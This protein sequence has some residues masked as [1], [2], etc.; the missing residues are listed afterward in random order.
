MCVLAHGLNET[1]RDWRKIRMAQG[2]GPV[3][4]GRGEDWVTWMLGFREWVIK[5]IKQQ[6][7]IIK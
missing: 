1:E 7:S 4:L 6:D 5:L 3:E 2:W